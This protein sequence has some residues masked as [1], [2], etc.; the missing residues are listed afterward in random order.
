MNIRT[1]LQNKL[2]VLQNEISRLEAE[3]QEMSDE[4][5]S[6]RTQFNRTWNNETE[7]WRASWEGMSLK[8]ITEDRENRACMDIKQMERMITQAETQVVQ[9]QLLLETSNKK[10]A[11]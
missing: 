6:A 1:E 8:S 9:I 11:T 5:I 3:I 7:E 10:P 2:A 4:T